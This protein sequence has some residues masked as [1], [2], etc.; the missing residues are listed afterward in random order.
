MTITLHSKD[1]DEVIFT[2]PTPSLAG[3]LSDVLTDGIFLTL[4]ICL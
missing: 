3:F 1:F 2:P 4:V